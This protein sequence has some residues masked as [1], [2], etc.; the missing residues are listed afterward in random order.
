MPKKTA[1]IEREIAEALASPTEPSRVG[2]RQISIPGGYVSV[3]EQ[4]LGRGSIGFIAM[5]VLGGSVVH[6]A[7]GPT[8]SKAIAAVS[9][10]LH[11]LSAA[12]SHIAAKLRH[13]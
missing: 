2:T 5:L 11:G 10:W 8:A 1:Q 13:P 7:E 6:S 4:V 3:S 9:T 12:T